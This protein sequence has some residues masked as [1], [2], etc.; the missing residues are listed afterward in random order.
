MASVGP[1]VGVGLGVGV[2]VGPGIGV[3]FGVG[4]GVGG[5]VG[6]GVGAGVGVG[7]TSTVKFELEVAIS[8][9]TVTVMRPV[10]APE[11][12]VA[13]RVVVEAAV[14]VA[15]TPLN[16]TALFAAVR[17]KWVPSMVTGVPA[18]PELG[19]KLAMVGVGRGESLC[20]TETIVGLPLPEPQNPKSTDPPAG[21]AE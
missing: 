19:E 16:S 1:G 15:A 18:A 10:V 17:E 14:T 2:G 4:V 13:V 8:P 9:P 11:G 20:D 3:G 5:G 6:V 7:E 12:T 21:T